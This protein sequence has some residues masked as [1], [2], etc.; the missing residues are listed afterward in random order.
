M[1]RIEIWQKQHALQHVL[2]VH[3]IA[4]NNNPIQARFRS[5]YTADKTLPKN[6]TKPQSQSV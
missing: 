6:L 5:A 1:T 2:Y 4:E 3:R